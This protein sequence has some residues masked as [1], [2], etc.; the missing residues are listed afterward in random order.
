MI[1]MHSSWHRFDGRK[2]R[3]PVLRVAFALVGVAVLGTLLAL[4]LLAG[5]AMILFGMLGRALARRPAT[6]TP[7]TGA[8]AAG[9][10]E[11]IDGEFRVVERGKASLAR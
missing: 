8:G 11:V 1:R 3:H 7:G 10:G 9:A 5:L 6:A 2:F 4:G